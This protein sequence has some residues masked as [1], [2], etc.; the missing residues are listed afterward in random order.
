LLELIYTS[1]TCPES[2]CRFRPENGRRPSDG[3]GRRCWRPV[4][5]SRSTSRGEAAG[6]AA[7]RS[8]DVVEEGAHVPRRRSR[9]AAAPCP[10]AQPGAR[11]SGGVVASRVPDRHIRLAAERRAHVCWEAVAIAVRR[12]SFPSFRDAGHWAAVVGRLRAASLIVVSGWRRSGVPTCA[13][14]LRLARG[15]VRRRWL[16]GGRERRSS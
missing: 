14:P 1:P 11:S 5:G 8:R 15:L 9:S 2:P 16:A 13:A 7:S 10:L 12:G 3:G 4:A 6:G